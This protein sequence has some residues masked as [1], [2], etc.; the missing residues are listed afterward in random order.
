MICMSLDLGGPCSGTGQMFLGAL[1]VGGSRHACSLIHF[2]KSDGDALEVPSG[3]RPI[4]D[5]LGNA[6]SGIRNATVGAA[7]LLGSTVRQ[8]ASGIGSLISGGSDFAGNLAGNLIPVFGSSLKDIIG[9][10]GKYFGT[11]SERLGGGIGDMLDG[12]Y[13]GSQSRRKRSPLTTAEQEAKEYL[14][15]FDFRVGPQASEVAK[16]F[17]FLAQSIKEKTLQAIKKKEDKKQQE[18]S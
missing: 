2:C 18:Q 12:N 4:T 10:T 17:E 13:G 8:T 15:Q 6:A 3:L 14:D 7:S 9:G 5:E 16:G 1:Q 11:L